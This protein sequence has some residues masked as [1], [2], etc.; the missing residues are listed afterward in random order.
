MVRLYISFVRFSIKHFIFDVVV[1]VITFKIPIFN[2][3]MQLSKNAINFCMLILYS[4]T[5]P[6]S[7]LSFYYYLLLLIPIVFVDSKEFST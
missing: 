6:N 3:Q 5:L 1:N 4:A 2:H 7:L